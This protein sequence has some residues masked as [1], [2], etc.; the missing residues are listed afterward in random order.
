MNDST[1]YLGSG[2]GTARGL[3]QPQAVD[4]DHLAAATAALAGRDQGGRQ[5]QGRS[6][7]VAD[8]G[9]AAGEGAEPIGCR[10]QAGCA[11]FRRPPPAGSRVN[12]RSRKASIAAGSSGYEPY[13]RTGAEYRMSSGVP[14]AM[15]REGLQRV[16]KRPIVCVP[17]ATP[18]V[19]AG[20]SAIIHALAA[21]APSPYDFLG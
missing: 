1:E 12:T 2:K 8:Q 11:D 14:L 10:R 18:H 20:P 19:S 13:P 7:S 15:V 6:V 3:S 21:L 17:V 9:M 16:V 5:C 4:E